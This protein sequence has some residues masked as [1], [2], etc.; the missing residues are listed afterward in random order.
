MPHVIENL[1][2][3][4]LGLREEAK[5]RTLKV[6]FEFV[7][8][9]PTEILELGQDL[10][11]QP[12]PTKE[13]IEAVAEK[14]KERSILLQSASTQLTRKFREW[15]KQGDYNFRFDADGDHFRIWV[16][17]DQRPEEIEL[18]GRSTGL[19]WFLSFFL[20][21]LVESKDAHAGAI[22]LLDEAGG[23]LHPLS[24]KDLSAFFDNLA[25]TNQVIQAQGLRSMFQEE[26]TMTQSRNNIVSISDLPVTTALAFMSVEEE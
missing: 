8:L 18:E 15:W 1:K 22:L 21:F 4:D 12:P 26:T 7:K 10:P 23:S 24:Q 3:T 20:V 2:R 16:S 13:Q 14:K 25:K 19:Q 17:D 9:S 6:L 11:D 5:V